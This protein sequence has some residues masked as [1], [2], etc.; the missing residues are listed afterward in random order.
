VTPCH[1]RGEF[2]LGPVEV[3]SGD[4]FGL[5]R[6]RRRLNVGGTVI[7]YPAITRLTS[8]GKLPGELPG[9]NVQTQR[10]PFSTSNAAGVR[11]YRPGDAMNRIHWLS[12]ARLGRLMVKE[13]DLDPISD[14]WL[15]LDLDD[16]V[17]AGSGPDST[18]EWSVSVAASLA[19]YFADQDRQVGLIT[20]RQVLPVDR[21]TRQLHKLLDLLAVARADSSTPLEQVILGEEVRFTRGATAVIITP[22]TDERWLETCRLLRSRGV[23]VI[24]VLLEAST[25]G[26]RRASLLSV[27]SLAAAAIPTYLVKKGDN[28]AV[29]LGAPAVGGRMGPRT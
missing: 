19:R 3:V 26:G 13:F 24:A 6:S 8:F 10:A 9:G 28:L 4:P 21:G 20:Q 29:A 25:F 27:S 15:I 5:F 1:V 7:V 14:V 17:Q 23:A 22:S 16:Q 11:D 18:E 12:S 2:V